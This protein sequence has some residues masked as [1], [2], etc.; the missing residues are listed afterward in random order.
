MK[1]PQELPLR[2][3]PPTLGALMLVPS[4]VGTALGRRPGRH[5]RSSS[6]RRPPRACWQP[7]TN[8]IGLHRSLLVGL[9]RGHGVSV[10]S[11]QQPLPA[12]NQVPELSCSSSW[13]LRRERPAFSSSWSRSRSLRRHQPSR[14]AVK[15]SRTSQPVFSF[16]SRQTVQSCLSPLRSPVVANSAEADISAPSLSGVA[17]S[18]TAQHT[19]RSAAGRSTVRPSTRSSTRPSR[20]LLV[21]SSQT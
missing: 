16:R 5:G 19:Q 1:A 9:A 17:A 6:S 4:R 18:A 14:D 11:R 2:G 12:A 8:I 21:Q 3:A 20:F 10:A 15:V 13:K 7:S